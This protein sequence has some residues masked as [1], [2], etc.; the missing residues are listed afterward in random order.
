MVLDE[1]TRRQIERNRLEALKKLEERR[2]R[3][4][5]QEQNRQQQHQN[6]N[7]INITSTSAAVSSLVPTMKRPAEPLDSS[8][9]HLPD[10]FL[11]PLPN[12]KSSKQDAQNITKP[13]SSSSNSS[14]YIRAIVQLSSPNTFTITATTSVQSICRHI[15]SE[16]TFNRADNTYTVPLEKYNYILE[17][18]SANERPQSHQQI[19]KSVLSVFE[20]GQVAQRRAAETSDYRIESIIGKDLYNS[21]FPYQ[22]DGVK[23]AIARRG[24]IIFAD[25]MGLGKSVQAIATAVYFRREWPLLILAP[26]SMVA[27]WHQQI[28]RWLPEEVLP[29]SEVQVIYDGKVQSICGVV[30]ILSYD[31]A[32]KLS[33]LIEARAFRIVIADECHALRNIE[34]KRSKTLVPIISKAER[35]LLLSGTPA[36]S[37]PIE[38]FPQ[39]QIINPKLFPKRHDFALRYC[40]AHKNYF[41]G[42]DMKGSSNL[43]E[44]QAIL[45][46]IIMIRRMKDQVL[47]ELP[48]KIR[49]QIFLKLPTASKSFKMFQM[50]TAEYLSGLNSD[51]LSD[52]AVLE[53]IQKKAEFMALWKRTAEIKLD[54]M[55]EYVEDLLDADHKMLIFAHHTSILDGFATTFISKVR[56]SFYH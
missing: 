19:P 40:E 21:L 2:K 1:E 37:R 6:I 51:A 4:L 22:R 23:M 32:V 33:D 44:L 52:P 7:F 26:A 56:D 25:E 12:F 24:R 28:L 38:L 42:W 3:L 14:V 30:T 41:G 15:L 13:L 11:K 48:P 46:N 55:I 36:L 20:P 53:S 29:P 50:Q 9:R 39:I 5:E 54:A 16:V 18:L 27:S 43:T 45:E 34:T 8:A 17:K 49:R 10:N 31:L 47:T 35:T